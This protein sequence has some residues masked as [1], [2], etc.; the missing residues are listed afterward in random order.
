M[1]NLPP[2]ET[3]E[4]E[5]VVEAKPIGLPRALQALSQV[6]LTRWITDALRKPKDETPVPEQPSSD[7]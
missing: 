2:D 7:G 4:V 1:S 6:E 3:S 5:Q